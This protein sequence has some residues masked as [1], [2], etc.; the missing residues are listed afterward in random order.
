[1]LDLIYELNTKDLI[2]LALT[3]SVIVLPHVFLLAE[4]KNVFMKKRSHSHDIH[5]T[6]KLPV[7]TPSWPEGIIYV[8]SIFCPF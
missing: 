3:D 8:I 6:S 7:S 4:N 2:S 1:L 5:Y